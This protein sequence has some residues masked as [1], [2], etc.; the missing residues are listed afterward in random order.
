MKITKFAEEK[1]ELEKGIEV[2]KEHSDV[3][4]ELA[5]FLSEHDLEMPFSKHEFAKKIAKAHLEEMKNYYDELLKMEDGQ[6]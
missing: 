4:D 1:T 2:E 6:K 3:Y 5:S